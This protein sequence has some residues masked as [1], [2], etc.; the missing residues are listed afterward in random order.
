M[1]RNFNYVFSFLILF[2]VFQVNANQCNEELVKDLPP[3]IRTSHYTSEELKQYIDQ[4]L[5]KE[6]Y[7]LM[8]ENVNLYIKS[9][10]IYLKHYNCKSQTL[11]EN[12]LNKDY[13]VFEKQNGLNNISLPCNQKKKIIDQVWKDHDNMNTP[14][15]IVSVCSDNQER[16]GSHYIS[17]RKLKYLNPG[18]KICEAICECNEDGKSVEYKIKN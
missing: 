12:Q 10:N 4:G 17:K 3:N 9:I 11:N 1:I 5:D 18:Y 8:D 6:L 13:E 2:F 7:M 14:N 15:Y 16:C